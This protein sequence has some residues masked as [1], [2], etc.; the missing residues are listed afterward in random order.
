MTVYDGSLLKKNCIRSA[1]VVVVGSGAGGAV[2]AFKGGILR[3]KISGGILS[4]PL[5][6]FT[7]IV[8]SPLL[9]VTGFLFPLVVVSGELR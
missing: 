5:P 4:L 2:T 6:T 7:G 1:D 9:L 3:E 8:G